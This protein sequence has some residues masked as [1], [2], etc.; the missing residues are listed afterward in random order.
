MSGATP[1]R[2]PWIGG[3][4]EIGLAIVRRMAADGAVVP[5]LLGRDRERLQTAFGTLHRSGCSAGTVGIVDANVPSGHQCAIDNA[6][7]ATCA[8]DVVV[9]AVGILGAQEG[10]RH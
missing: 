9:L 5:Y 6:F 4:S 2:V 10:S 3:T 1:Q 7:A 8:F